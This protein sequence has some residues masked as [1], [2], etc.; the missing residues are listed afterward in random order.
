M[1]L[2]DARSFL[3]SIGAYTNSGGA[4]PTPE[5]LGV[6]LA[7]LDPNY[8]GSGLARV[9]F[10]GETQVSGKGFTWSSTYTPKR[11]DRIYMLAA[12]NSYII[13]GAVVGDS[14][15]E[16]TQGYMDLNILATALSV[17]TGDHIA[18]SLAS[19]PIVQNRYYRLNFTTNIYS[20]VA[21]HGLSVLFRQQAVGGT[22]TTGTTLGGG[23][24]WTHP[25]R[26]NVGI[27]GTVITDFRAT[28][29]GNFKFI[30]V[31][32][33]AIGTGTIIVS[34]GTDPTNTRSFT[35]EDMGM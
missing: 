3:E 13:G 6:R 21:D 18:A 28:A 26:V 22:G 11:N 1:A 5:A 17:T 24:I 10:D 34:A 8:P 2:E 20:S 7:T 32:A 33:R 12:G 19:V 31:V 23:T 29:T 9:I 4:K 14:V 25:S 35:I 27:S 30:C 15:A 16:R